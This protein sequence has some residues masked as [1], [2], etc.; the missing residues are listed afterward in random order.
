MDIAQKISELL[1][2]NGTDTHD[3]KQYYR[4]IK[5]LDLLD[6]KSTT[7]LSKAVLCTTTSTVKKL[8]RKNVT[9]ILYY[10]VHHPRSRHPKHILFVEF[11]D[12]NIDKHLYA[13]CGSKL[14][15]KCPT[16]DGATSIEKHRYEYSDNLV[17]LLRSIRTPDELDKLYS[18]MVR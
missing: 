1:M 15:R 14:H 7:V 4:V 11:Y 9:K 18:S 13:Y 6:N 17:T 3:Q 16:C 10:R 12:E 8:D 2:S 5:Y